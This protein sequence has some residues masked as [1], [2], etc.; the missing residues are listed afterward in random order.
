[1]SWPLTND[2]TPRR[3]RGA[4]SERW[5]GSG[6]WPALSAVRACE[7]AVAAIERLPAKLAAFRTG[8]RCQEPLIHTSMIRESKLGQAARYNHRFAIRLFDNSTSCVPSGPSAR[9]NAGGASARCSPSVSASKSSPLKFASGLSRRV[10]DSHLLFV[11]GL[12]N[13]EPSATV[14]RRSRAVAAG[15]GLNDGPRCRI[16]ARVV[17]AMRM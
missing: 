5:S 1:M 6:P 10:G 16:P 4:L 11:H 8:K 12:F 3:E 15:S 7:L 9:T 17:D 2:K 13:P 14:S